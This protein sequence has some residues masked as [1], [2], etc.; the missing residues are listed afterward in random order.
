MTQTIEQYRFDQKALHVRAQVSTLLTRWGLLPRFKHWLLTKDPDTGMIV[1]F[2]I[3]NHRYIAAHTSTPFSDYFDP[4]VLHDLE[5]ELQV[6]VVTGD[7]DGLR[8]AF[9]LDRGRFQGIR[10]QAGHLFTENG[11][12]LVRVVYKDHPHFVPVPLVAAATIDDHMRV[13]QNVRALVKFPYN[14][15]P[16]DDTATQFPVHY[17]PDN[18][19]IDQVEFNKQTREHESSR[20]MNKRIKALLD[21]SM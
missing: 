16:G 9:I 1:L 3:L 15:K 12:L 11:K 14:N 10:A 17:V 21:G 7:S 6:Q 5:H 19:V 18:V 8:Y 13:H 20:Q 4:H 2:G